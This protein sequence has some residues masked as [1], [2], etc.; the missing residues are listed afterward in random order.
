M[1]DTK[2]EKPIALFSKIEEI[3]SRFAL[4][5]LPEGFVRTRRITTVSGNEWLY[6]HIGGR[7]VSIDKDGNIT[8]S[9]GFVGKDPCQ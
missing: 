4:P 3:M 5:P 2:T 1:M 6:I 7:D 9:G 8:G